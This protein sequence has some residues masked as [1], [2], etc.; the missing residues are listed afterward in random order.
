MP[1]PPPPL[2]PHLRATWGQA[3]SPVRGAFES[4]RTGSRR[5]TQRASHIRDA[6]SVRRIFAV[7]LVALAPLIVFGLYN[8]GLQIHLALAGEIGEPL[9]TWQTGVMKTLGLGFDPDSFVACLIHGALYF[10]PLLFA[11]IGLV[12]SIIGVFSMRILER[13]DP[14]AALRNTT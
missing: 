13:M 1:V 9:E 4:L 14:A 3:L 11:M 5:T 6:I 7:Y 10:L 8:L 12:A 2:L